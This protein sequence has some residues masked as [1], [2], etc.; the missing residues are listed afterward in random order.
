[1]K[2][3]VASRNEKTVAAHFGGA[4][5]YVVFTLEGGQITSREIREKPAHQGSG[6]GTAQPG[7]HG[8]Q[9]R[10]LGAALR[11]IFDC[12]LVVAREMGASAYE[13]IQE[14]GLQPLITNIENVDE[15]AKACVEGR[16]VN[17]SEYQKESL[18]VRQLSSRL[19]ASG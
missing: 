13:G 3:A 4:T 17:H 12:D 14:A 8:R 18:R 9:R 19:G 1:M 15:V 7:E 6:R 5:C 11:P 10:T 2:L 16:L